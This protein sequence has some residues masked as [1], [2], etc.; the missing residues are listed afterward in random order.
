MGNRTLVM[1]LVGEPDS[2]AAVVSSR[3]VPVLSGTGSVDYACGACQ[4]VIAASLKLGEIDGA[5]IRCSA[6]GRVNRPK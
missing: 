4:T 2:G 3:K 6:C 1:E 5:M